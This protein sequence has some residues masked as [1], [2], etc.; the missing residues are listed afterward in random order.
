MEK[1]S[2]SGSIGPKNAFILQFIGS[3]IFLLAVFT[4][5]GYDYPSS[6]WGS[7]VWQPAFYAVAVIGALFLFVISF[8]NV[9]T[10]KKHW[11]DASLA[12]ALLTGISLVALTYGNATYLFVGL[13]GFSLSFIGASIVH[14]NYHGRGGHRYNEKARQEVF[15]LQFIGSIIFFMVAMTAINAS[16]PSSWVNSASA[17]ELLYS[18]GLTCSVSLFFI[19]FANLAGSRG[20]PHGTMFVT[21]VAGL[22]FLILTFGSMIYFG[23]SLVALV[24]SIIAADIL[25]KRI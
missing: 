6:L 14:S 20:T 9:L 8:S 24:I 25:W 1:A 3:I 5:M 23:L 16:F 4:A 7:S 11:V 22:S 2:R 19:S 21:V 17:V 13:L 15:I 12:A 18:V 10:L